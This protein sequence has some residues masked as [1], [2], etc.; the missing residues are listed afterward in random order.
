MAKAEVIKLIPN[1]IPLAKIN[2]LK[3]LGLMAK[4]SFYAP[5]NYSPYLAH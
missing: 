2:A 3:S 5:L 4:E 1:A